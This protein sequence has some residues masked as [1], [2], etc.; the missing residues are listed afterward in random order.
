MI[1]KNEKKKNGSLNYNGKN[2]TVNDVTMYLQKKTKIYIVKSHLSNLR[3]HFQ[4]QLQK[5]KPWNQV[6][7][8]VF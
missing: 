4:C 6:K 2:G 3:W 1:T 5:L 7:V 8:H